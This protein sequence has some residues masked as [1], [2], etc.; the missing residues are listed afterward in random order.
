M[1]N[2]TSMQNTFDSRLQTREAEITRLHTKKTILTHN[3]SLLLNENIAIKIDSH[4]LNQEV[5]S[6]K[7]IKNLDVANGL[8]ETKNSIN[9]L[10]VTSQARS[11]DFRALYNLTKLNSKDI[12]H[13]KQQLTDIYNGLITDSKIKDLNDKMSGLDISQNV[14]DKL[15]NTTVQTL[16][17][18]VAN[19][20]SSNQGGYFIRKNGQEM[21][22]SWSYYSDSDH[23]ARFSTPISAFMQLSV[24]DVITIHHA[25]TA[26]ASCLTIVTL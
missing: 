12:G 17:T 7:Q 22:R 9:M 13:A 4:K 11:E 19:I 15:I 1:E 16:T 26:F 10:K 20:L 14:T 18:K 23:T 5:E 3:Y 2:I 8:Q 24:Y 6:L 25:S 21:A